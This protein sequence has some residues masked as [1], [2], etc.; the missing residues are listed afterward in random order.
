M[1]GWVKLHRKS[2]DS[3]VFAR[4]ELWK[5]WCLCLILANYRDQWAEVPGVL[6]PVLVKRGQF[7]TGRF[8]LHSAYYP[9]RRKTDKSPSTVW[10]WLAELE[11]WENLHIK[12]HKRFTLVTICNYSTYQ[13]AS[14]EN[15]Q[16]NEP[17]VNNRCTTGEQPV[18]TTKK[19]EES[20]EG[21][22]GKE[23]TP[24]NPPRGK[25]G[26]DPLKAELPFDSP[27][28]AKA[29]QDFCQHRRNVKVTLTELATT[30]IL[31][32][33][34]KW[35]E[36]LAIMAIDATIASDKWTDIY[37]PRDSDGQPKGEHHD[38]PGQPI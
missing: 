13:A 14:G 18:H 4:P 33:C 10:R 7:I 26:F 30:R 2:I 35:G 34:Q 19:E 3:R 25:V 17:L 11:K 1:D 6:S 29:W 16:Q 36:V 24:L 20:K 5:L 28:F 23:E 15:E 32:K 9:K 21:K 38:R 8:Q 31:N 22:E 12:T 37:K 27:E